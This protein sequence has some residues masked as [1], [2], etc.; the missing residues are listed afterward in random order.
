MPVST[1]IGVAAAAATVFAAC[2]GSEGA[3][4]GSW[5]AVVDTTADTITVR[6]TSGSVW[7]ETTR[8]VEEVRIGTMDGA[9]E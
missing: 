8:L 5:T 2:S 7:G 3:G 1:V 9:D 6:T 4:A